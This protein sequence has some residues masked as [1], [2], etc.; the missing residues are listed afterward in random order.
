[1]LTLFLAWK[2]TFSKVAL[3]KI[4]EKP[5]Y[6]NFDVNQKRICSNYGISV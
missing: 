6:N 2:S 3:Y 5:D 4:W 1:M